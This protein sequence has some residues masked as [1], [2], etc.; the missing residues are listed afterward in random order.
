MKLQGRNLSSGLS[1]DD[2]R[3]LHR[4]LQQL[5]FA[6]PDRERLSGSFGPGTLDAVRRF[7]AS[8]QL[9]VTGIVDELT[10]AAMNRELTRV[11]AAAT[12][13]VVRGRVVNR[14][15]LLVTTGTVRAFDRDLRGEQ[16]LGESRLG[17]AGSYEIRYST[18]QFL[19]SEKGVADLVLR[20]VAVDGREL[21]AS[22][23]LF[24]AEPDLTVDIE[25]DSL[26][27]ASEFERY[28]A[29][30]R[31]VLQT[32][33]IADLSESDIDFLSEET[34]LPTLHVA[35]LTVAHRYAQEARVP[36]EI[37]YGL[38]RR[39]CPSDLGTLLL[40]STT[41]LRESISAAIDRQIIPGRV[42][43]SLE[44]S[45]TALSKL[46]QEFPLRGVDSGGPLAGLLSLAD[47]TP[48]EQ[49]QFIN[50][51]VNHE[52]A[53]ES[54]WKSVAQTPLAARAAR[55]QETFQ[56]GLATRNNLPLI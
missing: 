28:L 27:P 21:F 54:F 49:G 7:Q 26:E 20:L 25:L 38:F 22:E 6:I 24:Q 43:D 2:V 41:D 36:P 35:W 4:F 15:G 31:P 19:R 56:L 11:A 44:S 5:R 52:G 18:N 33:A 55:L 23:V 53:V 3:L 37:F 47:L 16:P 46:R 8:Q 1:G 48:I 29:E 34:T 9:T 14:D 50:A 39:G 45:L 32:V 13:S 10:V 30:L 51:Y 40:Q 12:T 17:A 42:R